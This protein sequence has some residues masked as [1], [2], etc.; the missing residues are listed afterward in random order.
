MLEG[1]KRS[2]EEEYFHKKEKELI[3]KM[4]ERSA[5]EAERGA[6]AKSIGVADE[7]I[8]ADLQALGYKRDTVAL[9]HL[10]PLVEMAWAEGGVEQRERELIYEAA[11]LRGIESGTP[12]YQQLNDWLTRRPSE[13]FFQ[14]T[15]RVIRAMIQSLPKD[16]QQ[17]SKRDLVAY[18]TRIAAASGG[19]LGL[20]NKTS[21]AEKKLLEKIAGELEG[22]G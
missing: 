9:L 19:I 3:E 13:E 16:E 6:M 22:Q 1:K 2:K 10:V 17:E 18:C 14:K 11:R 5:V 8:L 12:A 20:G 21:A 4:R 7:K 15:L